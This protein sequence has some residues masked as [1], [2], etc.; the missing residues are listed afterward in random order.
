MN[1]SDGIRPK[2]GMTTSPAISRPSLSVTRRAGPPLAAASTR[3][4]APFCTTSMPTP[5]SAPNSAAW[6]SGATLCGQNTCS[7]V[8]R[9]T[10]RPVPAM[11][12]AM[13]I[14]RMSPPSRI[15]VPPSG[16]AAAVVSAAR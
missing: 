7:L 4:I 11:A 12:W 2:N 14:P 3:S 6:S 15:A 8:I 13:S 9:I 10:R 5:S 1:S 16:K